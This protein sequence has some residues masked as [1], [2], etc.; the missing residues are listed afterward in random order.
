MTSIATFTSDKWPLSTFMDKVAE[1]ELQLPD[2]QRGWIWDDEHLRSLLASISQSYPIGTVM[3]LAGGN[4][5]VVFRPRPVEGVAARDGQEPR[6]LLLDGQQRLTSLYL[7]L[8]SRT[9]VETTDTRGKAIK[10]WYYIDL[11]K[12]LDPEADREDAIIGLPEDRII[13]DFRREVIADYSTPER[14]YQ[15]CLFPLAQVGDSS[16]WRMGF[17]QYWDHDREYVMLW[18]RFEREVV[19]RFEQYLLPFI[20]LA[21]ET[22]KD[23]VCLIFEKVNT[24][25]V[26]LTVF[27]LLTATFAAENFSLRDDWVAREKRLRKLPQ[28]SELA[29]TDFLQAVTLLATNSRRLDAIRRGDPG[30]KA[31]AISCK[32]K[33][34]LRLRLADYRRFA[35]QATDGFEAAARLLQSQKI[36]SSRDVP[37]RT[38]LVPLATFFALLGKR[39][40]S[41]GVRRRLIRWFWCGVFGE[42]YGSAVESRFARDVAEVISWI[43]GGPEPIT[44]AEAS[45]SAERLGRLRSRQSAAYKGLYALLMRDGGLDFRTADPIEVQI[46]F[47]DRMD[48]HHIFPQ[49]WCSD[50]GL[51]P[52]RCDSIINKTAISAR[53]NRMIGGNAPSVYLPRVQNWASIDEERMNSIL[54]SHAIDPALLRADDF[55][56]FFTRRETALLDRIEAAMGKPV[57]RQTAVEEPEP[58][59][60]EFEVEQVA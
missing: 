2:F 3:M 60:N 1:L 46:Y 4:P 49:K 6:W 15:E 38:Q 36:F 26:A 20:L 33:D 56:G 10:R 35:D 17:E 41:D 48:I 12:A 47:D 55:D 28:L 31:P 37:Y 16:E 42:L 51:A 45:F 27:E 57:Q 43:D 14:E 44:I 30:D 52:G 8:M 25:G 29:S 34:V 58:E 50:H 54:A 24:G 39:G 23:A 32:R 22:P 9:A 13:R 7:A 19:K 18:N 53:T 59:P 40:Q 21:S 5:D 11:R